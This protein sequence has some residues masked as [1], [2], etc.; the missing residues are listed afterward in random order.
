MVI[1][2]MKENGSRR[3]YD[4]IHDLHSQQGRLHFYTPH[5][6]FNTIHLLQESSV[7]CVLQLQRKYHKD[8]TTNC[9]SDYVQ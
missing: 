1:V 2:I 7:Y 9:L 8:A 3:A 6:M 5:L 4:P